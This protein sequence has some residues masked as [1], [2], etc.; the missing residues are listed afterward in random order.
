MKN[1]SSNPYIPKRLHKQYTT[2]PNPIPL[3][4]P[5]PFAFY[6]EY[7]RNPN[8]A[9][10]SFEGAIACVYFAR[11]CT[12]PKWAKATFSLSIDI[13]GRVHPHTSLW[14]CEGEFGQRQPRHSQSSSYAPCAAGWRAGWRS[15]GCLGNSAMCSGVR[16]TPPQIPSLYS[17]LPLCARS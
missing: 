13:S 16:T 1:W 7:L 3:Q 4:Y 14:K 12:N 10:W 6:W 2:I 17:K 8:P 9:Q 5:Q 11:S 15:T